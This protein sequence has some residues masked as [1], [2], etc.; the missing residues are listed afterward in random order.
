MISAFFREWRDIFRSDINAKHWSRARL[1]VDLRQY[2]DQAEALLG[3]SIIKLV[4][5]ISIWRA[6]QDLVNLF[7]ASV[8]DGVTVNLKKL[9]IDEVSGLANIEPGL[10]SSA[11]WKPRHTKVE[12]NYFP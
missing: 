8:K 4:P 11:H 12:K 2:P 1:V 10:V 7:L 5:E 6:D 3:S 9:T